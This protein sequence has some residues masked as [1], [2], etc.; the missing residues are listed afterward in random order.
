ME[1]IQFHHEDISE[2]TFNKKS[3]RTNIN[4]IIKKENKRAGVINIIFCSDEYLLKINKEYLNHD[5]YTDIITFDYVEDDKISGDLFISLERIS[6][7]ANTFDVNFIDE[8]KRVIYHGILH[9]LG[10]G[11]KT[12]EEKN[13]MR[14]KEDFYLKNI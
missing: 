7:N 9:L 4:N 14:K 5:Y 2:I 6:E 3:I 12:A 11:D 10:Y 8:F 1:G 13:Q